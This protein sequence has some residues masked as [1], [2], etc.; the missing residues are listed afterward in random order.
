MAI[1]EDPSLLHWSYFLAL[2]ADVEKVSRY[3]EFTT[4]NFDTFSIELAHLL[5]AAASEVDVVAKQV[6]GLVNPG[7]GESKINE[8]RA[9]LRHAIPELET[10][11]VTLPRY[12]LTLNP[13]QNWQDDKTPLWWTSYN[14]VKHERN[15][16]F[17]EANLKHS[18]NSLA[19]LFLLVLHFYKRSLAD[20]RIE[21]PPSIFTPPK[22]LAKICPSIEGRV[23]LF[24]DE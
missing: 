19:G 10:S 22:E 11:L 15:H 7:G 21:P 17:Q 8:Y 4:D 12:G 23:A 2:E 18:L 14:N 9:T 13:W 16:H 5:F 24:F 3:I 1:H 20:R 6:C